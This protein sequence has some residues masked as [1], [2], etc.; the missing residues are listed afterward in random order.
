MPHPTLKLHVREQPALA[1]FPK[2]ESHAHP[3]IPSPGAHAP[4]RDAASLR[5]PRLSALPWAH[6]TAVA[7]VRSTHRAQTIISW[8]DLARTSKPKHSQAEPSTAS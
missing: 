1:L 8:H 7:R 3:S 6:D 4:L 2:Q 5:P